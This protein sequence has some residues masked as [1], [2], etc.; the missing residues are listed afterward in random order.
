MDARLQYLTTP[1]NIRLYYELWIPNRPKANIVFLHGMGDHIGRYAEFAKHLIQRNFG[2]CMYDQRGHGKS[3]GRRAHCRRFNDYLRDLALFIELVQNMYPALPIF[4]IGHSFGGQVAINFAAKYSKGLRGLVALSP[5]IQPLLKI[6]NWK[7][8]LAGKISSLIPIVKF[9]T[10]VQPSQFSHDEKVVDSARTDPL[11]NWHVT[12]RL[13]VEI[14]KNLSQ[15]SRLAYQVKIPSLFMTGGED[16]I[17]SVEATRKF[18][19]SL[20]I[21]NKVLRI[22]PGLYHELLNETERQTVF[23]DIEMW[24]NDQITAF[25]RLARAGEERHLYGSHETHDLWHHTGNNAHHF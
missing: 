19:H 23:R 22:Y 5:N 14:L 21:Q 10:Q 17:C 24:L 15:I 6:P 12:A 18:Y 16:E 1:D 20:L 11:M 8:N 13:G 2:F 4:L 25:K 7:K 9:Y 3:G